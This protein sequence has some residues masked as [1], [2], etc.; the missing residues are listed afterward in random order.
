MNNPNISQ[1]KLLEYKDVF[2]LFDVD[3]NG[4][5]DVQEMKEVMHAI[6]KDAT[7]EEV[8]HMMEFV[9]DDGSGEIDFDEFVNLMERSINNETAKVL[10]ENNE[11]SRDWRTAFDIFDADRDGLLS[12]DDLAS[13]LKSFGRILSKSEAQAMIDDVGVNNNG[14]ITLNE[15]I[16][17]LESIRINISNTTQ[18]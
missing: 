17:K 1:Q 16:G 15:F 6:G 2:V 7:N 8:L 4:T 5:I 14:Y 10:K 12:A 9:D 18:Y 13:S 11:T 3:G